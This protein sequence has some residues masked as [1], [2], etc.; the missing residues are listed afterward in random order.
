MRVYEVGPRTVV[1]LGHELDELELL[2]C[3]TELNQ[4]VDQYECKVLA[5]DLSGARMV[6]SA[7]LGAL[8]SVYKRGVKVHV[9]NPS[10]EVR[11]VL[12]ITRLDR[13]LQVH[14]AHI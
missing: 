2:E 9:Y 8:T 6:P 4:L 11:E 14:D 3:R 12:R 13:I 10:S 7:V 5:L 1:G